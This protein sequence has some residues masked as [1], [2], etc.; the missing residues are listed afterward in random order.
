M[1]SYYRR[2]ITNFSVIVKPLI[3]LAKKFTKFEWG[4]RMSGCFGISER[5]PIV[6][7]LAYP[8]AGKPYIIYAD[9]SDCIGAC[10]CQ[11]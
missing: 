5:E 11:E 7:V 9:A 2:F 4:L 8:D 6:P 3:R 1:C 10:L